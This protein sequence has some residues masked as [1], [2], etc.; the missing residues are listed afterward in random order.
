MSDFVPRM[1]MHGD[2][3]N[4]MIMGLGP[5]QVEE[6]VTKQVQA[7]IDHEAFQGPVRIMPDCHWGA[8]AT[9]GFTMPIDNDPLR[10]VPNTVG[11]DIGCGL[12]A[13]HVEGVEE[14]DLL[15]EIDDTIRDVVP[16]GRSVHQR[17][18]YHMGDDFPWREC[19]EKWERTKD[20]LD[21]E[22][23]EWFDGYGLDEYFKPLCKRVERDM[24]RVINSMGT[25]GGGNHFIELNRDAEGRSWF[26]IHSGSRA[27]GLAIAKYWQAEAT[28]LRTNDYI[29][30]NLDEE[31][32]RYIVP[33]LDDPELSQWFRGGKG[34]S[35]IDSKAIKENVDDNHLIG[36][37]HDRIRTAHPDKRD[38]D[39]DLD[40]LED[41]EVAGYLVDMIYAQTYAWENR[42]VMLERIVEALGWEIEDTV[43][44]PHNMI[45]FDDL[46]LRKGAT[47]AHDGERFVL[48]FNMAEGTYI[49]EGKGNEKWNRSAPH[50]AGRV[51][52]RT[53]AYEELDMEEFE[54]QMDGIYSSSVT[55]DT[56]DEAPGAYKPAELIQ[57]A[58]GPT[59]EVLHHL[60]P[61]LNVKS[62]E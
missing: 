60:K 46:V 30:E 7:T 41:Q 58:I 51:M 50:G 53:Q 31:L 6:N 13:M 5:G 17:N 14:G 40:Y 18:D 35:Y 19:D 11:V 2:V 47:R 62:L 12:L 15:D 3:T 56:L 42:R 34:Q 55:E 22:D 43:H 28:G 16:M 49:C 39:E 25:L 59:A 36:Y 57:G 37:L 29:R 44:S 38:A 26:V 52:S 9:I 32:A 4:A 61:I 23:P 24:M 8:G 20:Q 54:E 33:D 45:D 21:L 10:I 27:I 48:P 1:P